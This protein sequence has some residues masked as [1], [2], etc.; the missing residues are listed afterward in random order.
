MVSAQSTPVGISPEM[1]VAALEQGS[2]S[3]RSQFRGHAQRAQDR[4]RL[5]A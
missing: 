3:M 2:R 1:L 5:S 4:R